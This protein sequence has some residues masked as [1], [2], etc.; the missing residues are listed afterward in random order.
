MGLKP[1]MDFAF[2]RGVSAQRI[3]IFALL[4]LALVIQVARADEPSTLGL[5]GIKSAVNGVCF[6]STRLDEIRL[7]AKTVKLEQDSVDQRQL[8]IDRVTNLDSMLDK[9]E[10]SRNAVFVRFIF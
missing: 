7:D 4:I 3:T 10:V 5:R 8:H 2:L 9:V 1:G 6:A